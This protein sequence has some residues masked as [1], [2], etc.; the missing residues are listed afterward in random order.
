VK[1]IFGRNDIYF[2]LVKF[3]ISFFVYIKKNKVCHD[4]ELLVYVVFMINNEQIFIKCN[5]LKE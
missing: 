3:F 5:L 1:E 4:N 2:T